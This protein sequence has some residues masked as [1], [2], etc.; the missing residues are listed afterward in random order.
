[1]FCRYIDLL[2]SVG[3]DAF[4][5]TSSINTVFGPSS[6]KLQNGS[7]KFLYIVFW[8]LKQSCNG[9]VNFVNKYLWLES[10]NLF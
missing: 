8:T 4:Y 6:A 10:S 7:S 3:D 1:M 5:A 9:K 2:D